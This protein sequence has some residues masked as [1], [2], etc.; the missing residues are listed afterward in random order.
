VTTLTAVPTSPIRVALA[1]AVLSLAACDASAFDVRARHAAAEARA[2]SAAV[3]ATPPGLVDVLALDPYLRDDYVRTT[4]GASCVL[5]SE[6][7]EL[8]E[9][10]RVRAPLP[11][12]ALV[13]VYVRA[14]SDTALGRIEVLRRAPS[15]DQIGVTWAAEGDEVA[16]VRWP[17]GPDAPAERGIYPRGGPLPRILRRIGRQARALTCR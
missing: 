15:G 4:P 11:D 17:Y 10:R 14:E 16:V 3:A 1:S 2:D 8:E 13:I 7:S 9:R 12:S 5:Q 6:P